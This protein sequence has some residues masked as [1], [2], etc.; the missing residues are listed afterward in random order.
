MASGGL[1]LVDLGEEQRKELNLA[2]DALALFAKHVG[3]YGAHAVAKQAGFKKGDV[4]VALDGKRERLS[5]G[6]F[7]AR[8]LTVRPGSRITTTVLRDGKEI[9]MKLLMQQ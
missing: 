7:L 3:E 5:E 9:E 6:Q 8:T 2:D 4:I 1:L